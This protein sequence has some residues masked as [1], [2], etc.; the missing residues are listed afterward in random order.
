MNPPVVPPRRNFNLRIPNNVTSA[1]KQ[2]PAPPPRPMHRPTS[3]PKPRPR[4]KMDTI[5]KK[6]PQQLQ[7]N[8]FK[9]RGY[10]RAQVVAEILS[11]EEKFIHQLLMLSQYQ[12]QLE[13]AEILPPSK[14]ET[15]FIGLGPII[16]IHKSLVMELEA[17]T[18]NTSYNMIAVGE[19]F[20]KICPFLKAHIAYATAYEEGEMVSKIC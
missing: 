19:I 4:P 18:K 20:S 10:H 6:P 14:L 3:K 9:P 12:K 5:P 17:K 15:L 16:E 1:N 2:K 7:Q 13:R 11:S 8:H